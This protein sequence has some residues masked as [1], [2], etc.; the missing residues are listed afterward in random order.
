MPVPRSSALASISRPVASSW[1]LV[2][3]SSPDHAE[4]RRRQNAR[5]RRRHGAPF[6]MR[7]EIGGRPDDA[8]CGGQV[9]ADVRRMT[10]RLGIH[11]DR[12]QYDVEQEGGEQHHQWHGG[13]AWKA[14]Q[15]RQHD[16]G[17]GQRRD[18]AIENIGMLQGRQER[19]ELESARRH[20]H[21]ARN[22][23]PARTRRGSRRRQEM[24]KSGPARRNRSWPVTQNRMPVTMLAPPKTVSAVMTLTSGWR[25]QRRD[26]GGKRCRQNRDGRLLHHRNGRGLPAQQGND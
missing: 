11:A 24:A 14:L 19:P 20:R 23:Q 26:M 17:K 22:Q 10:R 2:L 18:H 4:R 12:R 7:H 9:S 3:S 5:H 6:D 21:G 16:D 8:A 25:V 13:G 15:R 1:P